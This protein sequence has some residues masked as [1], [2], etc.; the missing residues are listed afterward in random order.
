MFF[1]QIVFFI[2]LSSSAVS[3]M[4][5]RSLNEQFKLLFGRAASLHVNLAGVQFEL[6]ITMDRRGQL[7]KVEVYG[8]NS[9]RKLA[10][11]GISLQ[12]VENYWELVRGPETLLSIAS[13]RRIPRGGKIVIYMARGVVFER[14]V[15]RFM[16]SSR[17]DKFDWIASRRRYSNGRADLFATPMSGGGMSFS[18]VNLVFPFTSKKMRAKTARSEIHKR[19]AEMLAVTSYRDSLPPEWLASLVD[20]IVAE[21]SV[22]TDHFAS[23]LGRIVA[24]S[25]LESS[26]RFT[27]EMLSMVMEDL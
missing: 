8:S 25:V 23:S 16:L 14:N 20:E 15:Y 2:V 11:R 7:T 21:V 24:V 13:E 9:K 1:R 3:E 26:L 18:L 17:G 4:S 6:E 10:E 22:Q 19:L 12:Q 27:E 5:P